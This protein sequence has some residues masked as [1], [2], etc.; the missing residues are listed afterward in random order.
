LNDSVIQEPKTIQVLNSARQ[1]WQ[2]SKANALPGLVIASIGALI[3]A[4]YY[5]SPGVQESLNGLLLLREQYG[6]WF[7][8]VASIIGAGL[9]PG[10]YLIIIG[11]TRSGW[12]AVLDLAFTCL[13]FALTTV[14]IDL[15]YQF[16]D[17]LWGS[18]I[19][20]TVVLGKV[21]LDQFIFTPLVG[22]Q[23]PAIGFRFRDMA[24]DRNALSLSLRDHWLLK[25]IIPMLVACWLTWIPGTLV[26]YSLPLPLQIPMMVLIQCFFSLV[27]AHAS[28]TVTKNAASDSVVS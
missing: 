25:V 13:V 23:I 14:A 22:L 18:V 19:T 11:R 15:F 28:A 4:A 10:V 6:I 16:Q 7:S 27:L 24:Y 8:V 12:Y 3:V 21:F 1:G 9:I 17:W 26:I 20:V 5:I 2:S